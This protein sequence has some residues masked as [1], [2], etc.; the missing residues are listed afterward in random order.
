MRYLDPARDSRNR[1]TFHYTGVG[2][3]V[4]LV[5]L[6]RLFQRVGRQFRVKPSGLFTL[7]DAR[8]NNLIFVGSPTENTTLREIPSSQEFAFRRVPDG[9][10]RWNQIIVDLHARLGEPSVYTPTP[11]P[12]PLDVDYAIISFSHGLDRARWT[13]ILSGTST[14]GTEGA[15]DYVCNRHS[16]DQ[17]MRSLN[18]QYAS[19][20][21]PFEALL[22]VKVANDVP[23]ESQVLVLRRFEN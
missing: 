8:N 2:E 15:V 19:D 1:V 22:R 10:G 11:R 5:E 4:D 13:L 12:R 20:L 7:D 16:L 21:K 6:N 14:V 23:I 18:I 17:L 9:S 3:V